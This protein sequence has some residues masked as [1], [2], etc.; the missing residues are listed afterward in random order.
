MHHAVAQEAQLELRWSTAWD[1]AGAQ[2]GPA[3]GR[4]VEVRMI[5]AS[6]CAAAQQKLRMV[7]ACGCARVQH[8]AAQGAV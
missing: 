1:R 7:A 4:S 2:L 5:A 6:G 3:R 8:W